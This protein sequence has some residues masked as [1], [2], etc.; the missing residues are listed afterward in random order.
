MV[1]AAVTAISKAHLSICRIHAIVVPSM[2]LLFS[3]CNM[4]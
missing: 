2:A 1:T 3:D 4:G